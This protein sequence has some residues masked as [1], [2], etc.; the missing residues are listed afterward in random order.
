MPSGVDMVTTSLADFKVTE[1]LWGDERA[2]LL[3]GV[4]PDG[5]PVLL[6][7]VHAEQAAALEQLEREFSLRQM[8]GEGWALVPHHLVRAADAHVLLLNDPGGV[9]LT[10]MLT[11]PFEL[12]RFL[13]VAVG[14]TQAI[15][16]MHRQGLIHRDLKPDNILIDAENTVRLTGFGFASIAPREHQAPE[17]LQVIPGTFAYMA[18]EQTGRMNRSVDTRSD[19]YSLGIVLYEMI[20]GVVPFSAVDPMEWVHCHIARQ[21]LPPAE[22]VNDLPVTVSNIIMKL[23]SKAAEDRYQS[24]A[25]LSVDLQLCLLSWQRTGHISLFLLGAQDGSDHLVIPEKLYGRDQE[26]RRLNVAFEKVMADGRT[27]LLLLSGYP[28]IGKSALANELQKQIIPTH[29][30][31]ASG[32]FDQY[33]GNIPFATIAQVVAGIVHEILGRSETELQMYVQSLQRELGSN[34]QL[35]I[36]LVPD[37]E[38]LIGKQPPPPELPAL[39]AEKRLLAVLRQFVSAVAMRGH[40][41]VV[42]FDDLQWS[43]LN[44]LGVIEDLATHPDIHNLLL[45]GS[46]RD[47][48]VTANHPLTLTMDSLRRA[49]CVVD[50]LV[51]TA[52]AVDDVAVMIS[53]TL[54]CPFSYAVP[55][56]QLVWEKTAGNPFFTIQ[57]LGALKEEGVLVF[58][59]QDGR[60]HWDMTAIH[61]KGFTDN[62]IELMLTK[63]QRLSPLALEGLKEL[64]CLGNAVDL[65][66]LPE[67]HDTSSGGLNEAIQMGFVIKVGGK[68]LKFAHDRVQEAAY[69]MIAPDQRAAMH[70]RI[71]RAMVSRLDELALGDV[72]FDVVDQFNRSSDL[73]TAQEERDML[74]QLNLKA[75]QKAK[76]ASA[77]AA[78]CSYFGQAMDFLPGDAW[79]RHYDDTFLVYMER[80]SA[81][82]LSGHHAVADELFNA[83]LENVR[84]NSDRAKVYR[85][86]ILLYQ[87]AGRFDAAVDAA[88]DA[89][90]QFGIV[91]PTDEQQIDDAVTLLLRSVNSHLAATDMDSLLNAPLVTDVDQRA[92]LGILGDGM[93]CAF[94]ARPKL[95]RMFILTALSLT[96]Q[97]GNTEESS[98]AYMGYAILLAGVYRDVDGAFAFAQLALSLQKRFGNPYLEGTLSC[99]YGLF[100]NSHRNPIASSI[101]ILERAY[102]IC[103]QTGN[104]VYAGYGAL[105]AVWLTLERGAP[106]G[107]VLEMANKY[108]GFARQHQ[109]VGLMETLNAVETFVV[110][111]GQTEDGGWKETV[112]VEQCLNALATA[113]FGAGVAYYHL[114]HLMQAWLDGDLE[115]ALNHVKHLEAVRPSVMGW[116][117]ESS[118]LY[119]SALVYTG[120]YDDVPPSQQRHFREKILAN[121]SELQL[122][123]K[124]SPDNYL[125]RFALVSAELA[126]IDGQDIEA[127]RL[128]EQAIQAARNNG[129]LHNEG[130]AC[131]LA[132]K[133]YEHRHLDTNAQA[134]WRSAWRAYSRWDGQGKVRQLEARHPG[135]QNAALTAGLRSH[136]EQAGNL[137]VM[138]V[139]KVSQAV[140]GEV[141]QSNLV[142][143]LLRNMVEHAGAERGLLILANE[144]ELTVEAEAVTDS[145]AITVKLRHDRPRLDELPISMLRYV[146][147]TQQTVMLDNAVG[148]H[149]FSFDPYVSAVHLKSVLCM[150]VLK[151]STLV[152]VLYLENRLASDVFTPD[153]MTVLEILSSQAAIS[154]ENAALYADLEGRVRERT[155]EL[156]VAMEAA[157]NASDAKSAFLANMSHEIRTPLNGIIG[158]TRSLLRQTTEPDKLSR[159]G[160]I[161]Q[162]ADH[163]LEVI[164]D[165]LDMSKI[166]SGKMHIN[167]ENFS[168]SRLFDS[169]A[170]HVSQQVE[171][172]EITLDLEIS[173]NIPNLL[174]GDALRLRQCLI[175]Y[176]GNAVK[177]T[178]HG[179]VTVR[180]VLESQTKAGLLVRFEV[181][182]SGIGIDPSALNRLF[183][184]FEQADTSTTRE[185]GGTGLGLALIR[186]FAQLMNGTVG[187]ESVVGV[188]SRFWFTALLQPATEAPALVPP[189]DDMAAA[190][191]EK[192]NNLRLLVV[193]DVSLNRRVLQDMLDEVGL[194]CDMAE[195]GRAA[196]RMVKEKP[197]NLILMDMQMPIMDGITATQIIRQ[198]PGY[199]KTPIIAL[200]ANAFDEDRQRCLDAGMDDFLG[201]PVRAEMLHGTLFKWLDAAPSL[202]AVEPATPAGAAPDLRDCFARISDID[203]TNPIVADT[204]PE[205]YL[206][207]LQEF[208]DTYGYS[209]ARFRKH[210]ELGETASARELVHALRGTAGMIGVAGIHHLTS[211]LEAALK[212]GDPVHDLLN[213]ASEVEQRMNDLAQAIREI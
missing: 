193:D 109:H 116:V 157:R 65:T 57:F 108:M 132:A 74:W 80:S 145:N 16:Q 88:L 21:P 120:L 175:N 78:A 12:S 160:M 58:S 122:L 31:F 37:L 149:Q 210:L 204:D 200:T 60:W 2:A 17:P 33:K 100:I 61:N 123:A 38:L 151:Q 39:E 11:G 6:R 4:S 131:E 75:G 48:E 79:Q 113:R 185:Y 178:E 97:V 166:E 129:F 84:S 111:M 5:N 34:G 25:G 168:L 45:I 173:S 89:L 56:A 30:I 99:R 19:L 188:G 68:S 10:Q 180:A 76:A 103:V 24:A 199:E 115:L 53:D 14:L 197:Y 138:A 192:G 77:F 126:R 13:R 104:F 50:D 46:F 125:T 194:H 128:Y 133:F 59:A 93:P 36:G 117:A 171:S 213:R 66:L 28:G 69:A 9:T 198:V 139:V 211:G 26:I 187:V 20:T 106:L 169:V 42:F 41:L 1:T 207:F 162:A 83:I 164:N 205:R 212:Q 144:N 191:F 35:L 182:D 72:I 159:L 101:A 67:L 63:F 96:L 32:K 174:Y 107:D 161:D 190:L 110:N 150:P 95:Y 127:I 27:R 22:Q 90:L 130:M 43:D 85:Q 203:I 71:G 181:E 51:L 64:A 184:Q 98:A 92:V 137:D 158:L 208:V 55:L 114:L 189:G 62:V 147:R 176:V 209:M 105:D 165:I 177:F 49:G 8:L 163:L 196:V 124:N 7:L 70:L 87:V 121:L 179:T 81:E 136:G 135:L 29:G 112:D 91:W 118:L 3:R 52:L 201:K 156:R 86:R 82:F 94:F 73:V 15:D 152:G 134:H 119:Y 140:S 155:E 172:K 40:P 167:P 195:N 148:S 153:R 170:V 141:V 202:D 186:K 18:P 102:K 143:T 206:E 146:V 183:V 54:N 154:L 47:N 44:S 142:E 23:L